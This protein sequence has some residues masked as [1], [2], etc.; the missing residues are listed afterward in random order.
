MNCNANTNFSVP[1]KLSL[2]SLEVPTAMTIHTGTVSLPSLA[3]ASVL[4][5]RHQA[6]LALALAV[7]PA[8]MYFTKFRCVMNLY[9]YNK[10][11]RAIGHQTGL[12]L[13]SYSSTRSFRVWNITTRSKDLRIP[14]YFS[15]QTLL[16]DLG[17]FLLF[18]CHEMDFK[19]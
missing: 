13:L 19:I 18:P 11:T 14:I 17:K 9:V 16:V 10:Y 3:Q 8:M 4:Q 1:N 5:H 2:C 15:T 12:V 7:D 6:R